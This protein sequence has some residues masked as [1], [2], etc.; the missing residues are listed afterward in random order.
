MMRMIMRE[1]CA[2]ILRLFTENYTQHVLSRRI[3]TY[4]LGAREDD[5]TSRASD[6]NERLHL[7]ATA[8]LNYLLSCSSATDVHATRTH[9][10]SIDTH[11]TATAI[12]KAEWRRDFPATSFRDVDAKTS[13]PENVQE[14]LNNTAISTAEPITKFRRA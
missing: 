12:E 9:T 8:R 11:E 5:I 3:S 1:S 6:R 7:R 10:R 14:T 4:P 2:F 13:R